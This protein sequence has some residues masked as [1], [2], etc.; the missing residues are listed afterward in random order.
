MKNKGIGDTLND[1]LKEEGILEE[2]ADTAV[3]RVLAFQIQKMMKKKQLTKTEMA[4][5]MKTSRAALER[6]LEPDNDSVTLHTLKKAAFILGK[7][8]KIE[9]VS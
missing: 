8:L 4:K 7:R 5:Q 1:F 2:T 9:L 6:L 3:K